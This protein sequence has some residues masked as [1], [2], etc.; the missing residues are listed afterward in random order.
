MQFKL[1]DLFE[2]LESVIVRTACCFNL[3]ASST[4]VDKIAVGN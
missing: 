1:F 4:S 3:V 2:R